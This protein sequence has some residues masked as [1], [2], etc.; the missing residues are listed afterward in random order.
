MKRRFETFKN[1]QA[2]LGVTAECEIAADKVGKLY[3]Y[4]CTWLRFRVWLLASHADWVYQ[5]VDIEGSNTHDIFKS[6]KVPVDFSI[7]RKY[8]DVILKKENG[9][10]KSYSTASGFWSAYSHASGKKMTR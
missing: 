5:T 8:L 2:A 10:F 7:V 9:H 1:A 6:I 3:Q 4:A